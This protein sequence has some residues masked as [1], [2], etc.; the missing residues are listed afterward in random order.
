MI[1]FIIPGY[2]L[3]TLKKVAPRENFVNAEG[4]RILEFTK[5]KCIKRSSP[6]KYHFGN[7]VRPR[8]SLS[9]RSLSPLKSRKATLLPLLPLRRPRMRSPQSTIR[10][11]TH[12]PRGETGIGYVR[13]FFS[14]SLS[15]KGKPEHERGKR[16]PVESPL[17]H[18]LCC[19]FN[20]GDKK[21]VLF[22]RLMA[23]HF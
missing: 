23:R 21:V 7:A 1:R 22:T 13:A 4:S 5:L 2:Q 8:V 17:G 16:G 19:F 12:P 3:V 10:K 11:V 18:Q 20:R 15:D 14:L 9:V 6:S